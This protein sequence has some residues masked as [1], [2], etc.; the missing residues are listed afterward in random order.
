MSIHW[1]QRDM[2]C[3][4]AIDDPK[5]CFLVR[6][7][8]EKQVKC[9]TYLTIIKSL[10]RCLKT[11]LTANYC[12]KELKTVYW[13]QTRQSFNNK[14]NM[15]TN[16]APGRTTFRPESQQPDKLSFKSKML[17]CIHQKMKTDGLRENY[18]K[19]LFLDRC[20]LH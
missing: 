6:I 12:L 16:N 8:Q 4:I 18:P 19:L 20:F 7:R 10:E 17:I 2:I 15:C 1:K 13:K 14:Q 5:L 3:Y 11:N 9:R